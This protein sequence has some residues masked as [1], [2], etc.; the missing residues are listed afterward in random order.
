MSILKLLVCVVGKAD[1]NKHLLL[2]AIES[3]YFFIMA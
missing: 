2:T 1:S 3:T